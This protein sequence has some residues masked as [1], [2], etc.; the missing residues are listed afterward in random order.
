VSW[1][2]VRHHLLK[3]NKDLDPIQCYQSKPMIARSSFAPHWR[4]SSTVADQQMI[5][6]SDH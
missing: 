1:V 5:T 3:I 6:Y 2:T 4:F